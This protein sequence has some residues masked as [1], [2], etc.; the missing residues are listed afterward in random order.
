MNKLNIGLFGLAL[1]IVILLLFIYDS[2]EKYNNLLDQI[3]FLKDMLQDIDDD[4]H[5]KE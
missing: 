3:E 4:I 2:N 5:K 1:V